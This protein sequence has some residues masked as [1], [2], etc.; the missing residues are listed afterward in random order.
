MDPLLDK[1]LKDE[2]SKEEFD[3]EVAKLPEDEQKKLEAPEVRAKLKEAADKEL[4]KVEGIRQ[5]RR[6]LEANPP[7]PADGTPD[8]AATLRKE[9]VEKAAQKLFSDFK[10]P[11]EDQQHYREIFG[12]NDSGHVDPD[13]IYKD[14]KRIYAAENSDSLLNI[15]SEYDAM[16]KGAEDFNEAN[17]G[18][19]GG[20]GGGGDSGKKFSQAA[21]EY[22][23][24]AAKQ[25][26]KLT[27]ADAERVLQR[28]MTRKF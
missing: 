14:F 9:N 4:G 8:Y 18:A 2:I 22:V 28:G 19:P 1:F 17:A 10:I 16:E 26:V 15:K 7:K 23:H 3:A 5:E 12:K 13:L 24:E 21:H 27:L 20:S 25:G 11:A 6:R